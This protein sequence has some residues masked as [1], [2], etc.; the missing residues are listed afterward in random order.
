MIDSKSSFGGGAFR[1]YLLAG[2]TLRLRGGIPART[3]MLIGVGE[4]PYDPAR[5]GNE[6]GN[7]G[8]STDILILLTATHAATFSRR[9][10]H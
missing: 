9:Y 8:V 4:R 5:I 10:A 6:S 3:A 1:L 2:F 7:C